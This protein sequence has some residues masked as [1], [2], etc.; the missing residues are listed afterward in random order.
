MNQSIDIARR[1]YQAY[2]DHDRAAIEA[3][4]ADDFT[5]TSPLDNRIDRRTYFERCWPNHER[6]TGFDFVHLIADGPNVVITYEGR[7]DRDGFRNTEVFTL[8]DDKIVAVEVYFGW[9]LPH[10]AP[11]GGFVK[12]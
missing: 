10:Q 1:C 11:P 7:S 5:F 12:A 6:I 3:L 8:R 9:S 4:L 2:M